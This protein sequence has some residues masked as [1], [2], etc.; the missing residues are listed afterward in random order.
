MKKIGL[1][2]VSLIMFMGCSDDSQIMD[3]PDSNQT[4][5]LSTIKMLPVQVSHMEICT[6]NF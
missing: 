2:L 5:V 1:F 4:E 6:M 3:L